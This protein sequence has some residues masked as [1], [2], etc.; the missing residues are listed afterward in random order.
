MGI[1]LELPEGVH[2]A[3]QDSKMT[4][5]DKGIFIP[6]DLSWGKRMDA[7][8]EFLITY[9]CASQEAFPHL[10]AEHIRMDEI[11]RQHQNQ[12]EIPLATLIDRRDKE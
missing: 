3:F 11:L 6:Y 8:K 9:Y 5:V 2:L 10:F 4:Q 12:C 7:L 1:P